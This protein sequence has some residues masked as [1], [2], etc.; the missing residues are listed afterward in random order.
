[1]DLYHVDTWLENTE[2]RKGIALSGHP[3]VVVNG[4]PARE[5]EATEPKVPT[6]NAVGK[7]ESTGASAGESKLAAQ[8]AKQARSPEKLT[9]IV[10]DASDKFWVKRDDFAV[11]L[12]AKLTAEIRGEEVRVEGEVDIDRGYLSLFGK[13]FEI[14]RGGG[15]EFIG[16]PT[17]NPVLS[18]EAVH[19]NRRSGE[20]VKVRITGRGDAPQLAF[21][22]DD[23][24]VTAGDA[25]V[26]L[27]G[28]QQ[29][30]QDPDAAG[31]QAR[32]FVGG[33]TAGILATTARREL[34]SAA[35]IVMV[36]PGGGEETRVR[37]GF[38]LDSLVP[39]FLRPLVT[40]L[41]FEGIVANDQEAS[42]QDAN[43]N[44]GALLEIYFPH[45]FFRGRHCGQSARKPRYTWRTWT[46]R[47]RW[48]A[49]RPLRNSRAR[50]PPGAATTSRLRSSTL[51]PGRLSHFC[52]NRLSSA[53][54]MT[55]PISE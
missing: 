54:S 40:G 19:E 44:G 7:P 43:V 49:T 46:T 3:D 52:A 16:S 4:V 29:S 20:N 5:P 26:A 36:E 33:L 53:D 14:Q 34:G 24:G 15:L 55:T 47:P 9:E 23:V 18:I 21:F 10:L 11:K 41:Y 2:L 13:V 17:P 1:M 27:F 38:E 32:D 12:A 31:D 39:R 51:A 50:P 30:N 45:D 22:V 48:T 28:A 35:P 25:F 42:T 6:S 8:Q 37:A